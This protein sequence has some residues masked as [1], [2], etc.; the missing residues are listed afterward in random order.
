MCVGSYY[1]VIH[2]KYLLLWIQ[3]LLLVFTLVRGGYHRVHETESCPLIGQSPLS[4]L[5]IG[6]DVTGE[7]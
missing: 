3:L 5:L 6:R 2:Y 7:M 1:D 4:R